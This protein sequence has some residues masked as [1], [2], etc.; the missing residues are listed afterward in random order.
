MRRYDTLWNINVRKKQ[1]Q[2]ETSTV[3]PS[4]VGARV[5]R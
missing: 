4:A 2:R 5:E 3:L 1:Q